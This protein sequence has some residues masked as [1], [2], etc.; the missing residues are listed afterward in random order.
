MILSFGCQ[1][2]GVFHEVKVFAASVVKV[3]LSSDNRLFCASEDGMMVMLDV[4]TPGSLRAARTNIITWSQEVLISKADL[5]D[6]IE[7]VLELQTKV[8]M[9]KRWF[10][11]KINRWLFC[12]L[13]QQSLSSG[14]DSHWLQVVDTEKHCEYEIKYNNEQLAGKIRDLEKHY[15]GLLDE[16]SAKNQSLY[17]AKAE[18][19]HD[20]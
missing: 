17:M 11:N 12:E 4:R 15:D 8:H 1:A 2:T 18:M 16:A 10:V 14:A 5:E 6:Y 13:V 3:C 9:Q 20:W 19:V 7:R